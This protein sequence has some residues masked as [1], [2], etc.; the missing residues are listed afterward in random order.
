MKK[1][2]GT[3][4]AASVLFAGAGCNLLT[5]SQKKELDTA[6]Q[7]AIVKALDERGQ[8][9]A[10]DLVDRLVKE[11]KLSASTAEAVKKAIPVGIEKVKKTLE[12]KTKK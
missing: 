4:I 10:E 5:D 12:E 7:T 11:G 1:I 9:A 8:K 6:I 2:I 3:I